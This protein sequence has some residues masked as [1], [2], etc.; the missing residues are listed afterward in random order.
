MRSGK[1][2]ARFKLITGNTFSETIVL[3][4]ISIVEQGLMFP[5]RCE[6][7]CISKRQIRLTG[8]FWKHQKSLPVHGPFTAITTLS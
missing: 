8:S 7:I 1:M 4:P 2:L 6:I 3:E 5:R